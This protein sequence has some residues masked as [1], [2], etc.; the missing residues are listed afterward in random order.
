[1]VP[2]L[3]ITHEYSSLLSLIVLLSPF[4]QWAEIQSERL[5]LDFIF[6]KD[7]CFQDQMYRR[8]TFSYISVTFPL[9][10]LLEMH[11]SSTLCSC[12][13]N[14]MWTELASPCVHW[15]RFLVHLGGAPSLWDQ[16]WE[17][18]PLPGAAGALPPEAATR[19]GFGRWRAHQEEPGKVQHTCWE[20]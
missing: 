16:S 17:A 12:A 20:D 1:M 5:N 19:R 7:I 13:C 18:Q 9:N 11:I 15:P 3:Y 10:S 8:E 2:F 6:L 14:W 4:V